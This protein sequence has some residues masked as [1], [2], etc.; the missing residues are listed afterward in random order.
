MTYTKAYIERLL[1]RSMTNV[2]VLMFDRFRN[3]T[4]HKFIND[5]G[6]LKVEKL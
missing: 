1:N 4:T 3:T 5:N 6:K 2:E